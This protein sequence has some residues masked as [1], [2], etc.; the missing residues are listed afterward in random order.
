V[1]SPVGQ[2]DRERP[3]APDAVTR[4]GVVT[5]SRCL[6]HQLGVIATPHA[7][8][9][10]L[11]WLASALLACSQATPGSEPARSAEAARPAT[12]QPTTVAQAGRGVPLIVSSAGAPA[13]GNDDC[14]KL[15]IDFAPR[16][17]SVF[18]LVD[19][20]SSMFER[21][22]W[23]P[24][25]DG[26]LA[27]IDQLDQDIRFGF[28]SYTGAHNLVCP[29]LSSIVPLADANHAAIKRAYDAVQKPE[30]KGET[31]T[32]LAHQEVVKLLLKE[33]EKSPKYVLLVTDGEPDFCDDPNVTCSRDA[34][35]AAV[36]AAFGQGV[37]TFIFS[38]GGE[39]SR[40]HLADV[41]N[42]GVGLP[43]EDH[44]MSVHYQC[45]SS[46]ATYGAESGRAPFFEP[47]VQDRAALVAALSGAIAG[48]RSCIFDL[49]GKVRIDLKL[50]DQG[51]VAIDG[52]RVP[53][54]GA[55]GYRM[56]SETQLELTGAACTRL[57]KP[58]TQRVSI[59]FPCKAIELL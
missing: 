51:E 50:A 6:L 56:N 26:V 11:A 1:P 57:R 10:R 28:S 35:V 42:A 58:E 13:P 16:V 25:K 55:D 3:A 17:P 22:L 45:P 40:S 5:R 12:A 32:S 46:M 14:N 36:Q 8:T 20:S 53:Y 39:V 18:I 15:E 47:D 29:E 23:T 21:S 59:N 54:G 43:V 9:H 2:A 52:T 7:P 49:Q 19:R 31:P 33:P 38:V 27:V 44:Q 41:A 30:Y 34:V 24:L 48:V 4:A 37:G